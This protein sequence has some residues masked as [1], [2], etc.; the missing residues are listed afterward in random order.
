MV[1]GKQNRRNHFLR[2]GRAQA[3]PNTNHIDAFTEMLDFILQPNETGQVFKLL[4]RFALIALLF[5]NM[6]PLIYP[7]LFLIYF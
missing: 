7:L 2:L 4:F 5:V 6:T 3:K 1:A